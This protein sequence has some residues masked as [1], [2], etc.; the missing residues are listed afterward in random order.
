V[1]VV[2]N[3]RFSHNYFYNL[4][5]TW[6]RLFGNYSGLAS[7]D[8]NGRTDP[9]VSR[10]FDYIVNGFTFNGTP[11]NGLLAT[12]RTHTFKAYG[13]YNFDWFGSKTNTTEISFFQQIL[14]G[15]PQTTYIG[16]G[17]SSIVYSKRGDLGRTPTFWQ[18]DLSLA[19]RYKF[20]KDSRYTVE[21]NVNVLNLFNNNTVLQLFSQNNKYYQSSTIG[22]G[23][24]D[25]TYEDTSNPVNA[26]NAILT[27]KFLPA[28]VDAT[29]ADPTNPI[30]LLYGK[31]SSYQAARNVRFGFRFFF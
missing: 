29:L 18:T 14:Q 20:G 1:E 27:G 2:F 26:L 21:F 19:H 10:Y 12:D 31:P 15:T 8:E 16:I 11:D 5:Y 23:D 28:Q 9:G 13:G 22:F 24:I 25:P 30:N 4:N 6:S 7:S 3:K 17:N